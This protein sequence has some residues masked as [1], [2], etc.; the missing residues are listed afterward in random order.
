MSIVD[1]LQTLI[2]AELGAIAPGRRPSRDQ[3]R[4]TLEDAAAALGEVQANERRL[5]RE[6]QDALDRL[7]AFERAA[8]EAARRG[9][10][11]TARANL[12]DAERVRNAAERVAA[13]LDEHRRRLNEL[14]GTLR[15]LR[16]AA[17]NRNAQAAE[18]IAT[19]PAL[20]RFDELERRIAE[21]E[22]DVAAAADDPLHDPE[23]ASFDREFSR[24]D[25]ARGLDELRDAANGPDRNG[26]RTPGPLPRD[27]APSPRPR[28]PNPPRT[29]APPTPASAL[30][31]LRQAMNP[32]AD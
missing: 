24:L 1:R 20:E 10:D 29:G 2:R 6:Y 4:A 3:V 16:E 11:A 14:R 5:D 27:P 17:R 28:E 25:A 31:R 32:D 8:D 13:E 30:E 21:F 18:A 26:E 9:D 12:Q 19:A 15:E 23:R 7:Y 22:A